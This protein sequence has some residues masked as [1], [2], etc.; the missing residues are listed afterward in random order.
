MAYFDPFPI[1]TLGLAPNLSTKVSSSTS[2]HQQD[3]IGQKKGVKRNKFESD[4]LSK[5]SRK[6]QRSSVLYVDCIIIVCLLFHLV[7]EKL[8]LESESTNC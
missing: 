7:L 4:W 2:N 5:E 3:R 8:E 1:G 6:R